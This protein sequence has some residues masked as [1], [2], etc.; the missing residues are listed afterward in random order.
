[1]DL[2]LALLLFIVCSLCAICGV[3]ISLLGDKSDKR[4]AYQAFFIGVV[5]FVAY[6][7]LYTHVPRLV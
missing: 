4:Y 7:W 5:S 3:A 1:V 6:D 2:G